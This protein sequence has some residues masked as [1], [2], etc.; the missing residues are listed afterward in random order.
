MDKTKISSKSIHNLQKVKKQQFSKSL[1][2]IEV[3][4]K[5]KENKD[6]ELENDIENLSL[7][8]LKIDK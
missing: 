2:V 8:H 6:N 5:K 1:K 7:D 3:K 4:E